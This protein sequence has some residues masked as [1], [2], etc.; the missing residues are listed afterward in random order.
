MLLV[1]IVI[2]AI[3]YLPISPNYEKQEKLSEEYQEV[4]DYYE[5]A[6]DDAKKLY[7]EKTPSEKTI[8]EYNENYPKFANTLNELYEDGE[9]DED[10]YDS[11]IEKILEEYE[12][13]YEYYAYKSKRLSVYQNIASIII[14]LLYFVVLEFFMKGQTLGK[15]I[16][17]LKVV[18]N[19]EKELSIGN[20]LLRSFVLNGVLISII[21]EILVFALKESSY[22][23]AYNYLSMA[24]YIIVFVIAITAGTNA[25]GR[26]I[27]DIIAGTK[28]INIGDAN[29]AQIEEKKKEE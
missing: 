4:F 2:F 26:G 14:I 21:D 10:D 24:S 17:K 3:S 27:H 23:T 5:S 6:Y 9:F 25:D 15:K 1:T 7:N 13:E 20:Y 19:N 11:L 29:N 18:S 22:M 16:L 8:N 28:V 12:P